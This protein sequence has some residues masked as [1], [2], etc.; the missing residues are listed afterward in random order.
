M[1]DTTPCLQHQILFLYDELAVMA[2]KEVPED[3]VVVP[4]DDNDDDDQFGSTGPQNLDE[5]RA[6]QDRLN[7]T[8][9][10]FAELLNKDRKDTLKVTVQVW[11]CLMS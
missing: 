1:G 6:Y 9:D 2:E 8:L 7:K 4:D 5:A 10:D 3:V 11:K